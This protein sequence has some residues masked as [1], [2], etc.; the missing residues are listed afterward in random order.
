M[1]RF[2]TTPSY[3][4]LRLDRDAHEWLA[5]ARLRTLDAP[6]SIRTL[7]AG[8]SRVEVDFVESE[9]ALAWASRLPGWNEDRR[10]PA[11]SRARR[12]PASEPPRSIPR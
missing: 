9:R 8:R 1:P 2:D 6:G 11:M 5:A 3:V 4:V 10:P 12:T 7:L